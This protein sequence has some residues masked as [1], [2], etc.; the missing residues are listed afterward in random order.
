MRRLVSIVAA[1]VLVVSAAPAAAEQ[2]V[3][4]GSG[5]M[6]AI[7]RDAAAA[8]NK[9][10]P[11]TVVEIPDSIGT[12]GGM[13]AAGEGTAR[14]ARVGRKPGAKEAAYGLEHMVFAKQAV[15]F[16]AHPGV[17]IKSLTRAQS[18]D[19]FSGRI[20]NWKELGGPDLPVVVIARDPGET[21][22]QFIR[23]SFEEWKNLTMPPAAALAKS[24]QETI[25]LIASRPGAVGFNVVS[26]VLNK[27]LKPLAIGPTVYTDLTYPLLI[28]AVFVYKPGALTGVAK[29]F[30]D[31]VFSDEGSRIIKAGNAFPIRR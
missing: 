18:R 16:A 31:F 7:L 15:V 11:G 17:G 9:A 3:I 27:G 23:E 10:N 26:E 13:K 1:A 21:N 19:L 20:A 30:V 25:E 29:A 5:S 28:D 24:D 14:I 2:F 12:G 4:P 22:F 6:Q 8:F